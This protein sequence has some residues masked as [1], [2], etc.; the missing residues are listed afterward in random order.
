MGKV[1]KEGCHET[2][3]KSGKTRFSIES[4]GDDSDYL[5]ALCS[6]FVDTV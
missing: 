4:E 3:N 6:N 2:K 1:F 5:L